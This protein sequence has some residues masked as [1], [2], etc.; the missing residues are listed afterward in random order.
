[1]LALVPVM[2]DWLKDRYQV[3]GQDLIVPSLFNLLTATIVALFLVRLR[4][5]DPLAALL[6]GVLATL[7]LTNGYEEKLRGI[8]PVLSAAN[9]IPNL[10]M[11]EGAVFSL[12]YVIL[13][14]FACLTVGR[15]TSRYVLSRNWKPADLTGGLTVLVTVLFLLQFVPLAKA[16]VVEWPQFHYRPPK[17]PATAVGTVSSKPDIYYI[18][19][20]RYA[21]QSVLT[22]QYGFDNS[23]FIGYLRSE[24]FSVD[25]NAH[26]NYPIRLCPFRRR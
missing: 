5:S 13:V 17:L 10:D 2:T 1:M 23:D 9:P 22:T 12:V 15:L 25:P 20:D 11:N 4:R 14:F 3:T 6:A 16:L 24:G 8:Y 21:S 18:V 19:L 7:I 26:Q